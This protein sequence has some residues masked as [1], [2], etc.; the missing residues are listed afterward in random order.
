MKNTKTY[1]ET[2]AHQRGLEPVQIDGIPEGFSFKA[3]DIQ[4]GERIIKGQYIAYIP[5]T[6]KVVWT[7]DKDK[8]LDFY[9]LE[10]GE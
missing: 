2:L 3:P 1:I 6:E 10:H 9:N 8:L 7:Y 4:V 5:N